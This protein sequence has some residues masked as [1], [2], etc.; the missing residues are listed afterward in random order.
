MAKV[1]DKTDEAPMQ[2]LPV[3]KGAEAVDLS[4]PAASA[5]DYLRQVRYEAEQLPEVVRAGSS[6][7][8]GNTTPTR[9]PVSMAAPPTTAAAAPDSGLELWRHETVADFTALRHRIRRWAARGDLDLPAVTAAMPGLL[10]A[11]TDA[12]GWRRI[13]TSD[14]RPQLSVLLQMGQRDL[15]AHLHL[16]RRW[17]VDDNL[18]FTSNQ[19]RWI[20]GLLACLDK[21][22]DADTT[23]CLRGVCRGATSALY[24]QVPQAHSTDDRA[25]VA[26]HV[27]TSLVA[28]YFGQHDLLNPALV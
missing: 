6:T 28:V 10:P 19:G 21:L 23:A 15:N 26:A 8:R 17:L 9:I 14:R 2:A 7:A 11:V 20:Y 16:H 3:G 22:I 24:D 13:V 27:V 4:A 12:E 18:S 5:L 1:S 25:V